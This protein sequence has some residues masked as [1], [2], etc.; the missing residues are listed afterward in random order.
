MVFAY[1][2]RTRVYLLGLAHLRAHFHG[3]SVI[4][5]ATAAVHMLDCSSSWN[6]KCIPTFCH[7]AVLSHLFPQSLT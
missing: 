2:P 7:P 4:N 3:S 5:D 6:D 1:L